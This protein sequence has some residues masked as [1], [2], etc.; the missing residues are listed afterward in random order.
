VE[1]VG[2]FGST[3]NPP[4]RNG[5]SWLDFGTAESDGVETQ[6]VAPAIVLTPV[7]P[8]IMTRCGSGAGPADG[9]METAPEHVADLDAADGSSC[10]QFWTN[11]A[12]GGT[13][14]TQRLGIV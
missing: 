14:D 13:S 9:G 6:T 11:D 5:G 4:V 8:L 10:I 7:V 3:G 12:S 1:D 2:L